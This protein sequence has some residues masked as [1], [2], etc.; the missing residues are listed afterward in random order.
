MSGNIIFKLLKDFKKE[1]LIFDQNI[2]STL[3]LKLVCNYLTNN[4]S[5]NRDRTVPITLDFLYDSEK[6]ESIRAIN[7]KLTNFK[8]GDVKYDINELGFRMNTPLEKIRNSVGIFGCSYTFGVG[9]PNEYIYTN[10]LN[11]NLGETICNFGI[12]GAGIQKITKAF[13]SINSFYQLKKAIFVLPSLYRHEFIRSKNEV[14]E[15][16]D[17][18]HNY[19]TEENLFQCIYENFDDVT[20]LN[21][22]YKNLNL[23]RY[24]AKIYGT[25]ITFLTW[26][27]KT[28][29]L[30]RNF[31]INF[32]KDKINFIEVN[33][34]NGVESNKIKVNDFARDGSHPGIRSHKQTFEKIYNILK[35]V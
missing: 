4:V 9:V 12:P 19:R 15:V 10:L 3:D 2:E 11:D 30:D 20:F 32:I 18:I 33:E 17:L 26:C 16:L 34:M 14:I 27:G 35:N 21:E 5:S 1:H 23:I 13:I 6:E 28:F 7:N 8:L 25:E 22:Y 29:D 24:N 31:N